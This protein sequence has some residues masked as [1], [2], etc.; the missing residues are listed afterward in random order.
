MTRAYD[1]HRMDIDS[2]PHSNVFPLEH[3]ERLRRSREQIVRTFGDTNDLVFVRGYGNYG[4]ELIWAG[5]RN[6]LLERPHREISPEEIPGA[7]GHTA[8]ICGGGAFCHSFHDIMPQVL[9]N[10]E[11]RFERVIL[12]P[13]TFD[14]SVDAVREALQHT[15]AIVFARERESYRQ[16]QQLCDARLA[17]DAAFFFDYE[18]FRQAGSGILH[19][20][21][22]DSES[23]GE[24]PLPPDNDDISVTGGTLENWLRIISRHAVVQTDRAHV[25]IAAA[26]LGKEVEFVS[27][28]YFKVPAIADYALSD[29]PVRRLAPSSADI[30]FLDK[31]T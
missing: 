18:P 14:T 12:L 25:M 6:L 9:A 13:S 3:V 16:I 23:L 1:A 11:A 2:S 24:R 21:R 20:F 27:G 19:A 26:L 30:S 8:L 28:R 7:S 15:K 5:T 4:D 22:T 29:F 31:S 17:H 10:A